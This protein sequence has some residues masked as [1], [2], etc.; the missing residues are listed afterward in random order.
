MYPI[1]TSPGEIPEYPITSF[2]STHSPYSWLTTRHHLKWLIFQES[3]WI[4]LDACHRL[5][6][7]EANL[8]IRIQVN[9]FLGIADRGMKKREKRKEGG[10][11][12]VRYQPVSKVG[13]LAQSYQEY[14]ETV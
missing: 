5:G 4:G 10:K 13:N 6:P 3:F 2:F 14:L 9:V 1:T 7:L 11:A 12:R 8:E